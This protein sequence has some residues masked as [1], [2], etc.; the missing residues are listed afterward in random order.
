MKKEYIKPEVVEMSIN[1]ESLMSA[2][3]ELN[4]MEAGDDWQGAKGYILDDCEEAMNA[5]SSLW[6]E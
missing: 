1:N 4:Q 6:D 5:T 2:S 3:M